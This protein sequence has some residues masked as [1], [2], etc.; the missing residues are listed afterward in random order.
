[1]AVPSAKGTRL[2]YA[3]RAFCDPNTQRLN[4]VADEL[5]IDPFSDFGAALAIVKPDLVFVCTPPVF[6]VVQA[7]AAVRAGAHVFIEID[8]LEAVGKRLLLLTTTSPCSRRL[9]LMQLFSR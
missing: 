1:V 3:G 5:K 2:T 9:R 7:L 4:A 8:A 6:H